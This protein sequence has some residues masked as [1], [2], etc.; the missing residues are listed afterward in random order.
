LAVLEE[1]VLQVIQDTVVTAAM[2]VVVAPAL[3]IRE[4]RIA[5]AVVEVVQV[6]QAHYQQAAVEVEELEY[7]VKV[8]ADPVAAIV[9]AGEAAAAVV[10]AEH[11]V[12]QHQDITEEM[13]VLMVVEEED[14]QIMVLQ[15]EEAFKARELFVL[16]GQ[17]TLVHSHQHQLVHRNK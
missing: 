2:E 1:E 8:P 11:Q 14:L 3:A 10:L 15:V 7:T 16:S 12:I 4:E 13:E 9:A 17:E 6:D 5:E